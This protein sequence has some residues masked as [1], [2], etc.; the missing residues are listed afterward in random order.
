MHALNIHFKNTCMQLKTCLEHLVLAVMDKANITHT[1]VNSVITELL[2]LYNW[3]VHIQNF[4]Y[5]ILY[6]YLLHKFIIAQNK[7]MQ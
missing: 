2:T 5:V 3:R 6:S 7:R 4:T 1:F